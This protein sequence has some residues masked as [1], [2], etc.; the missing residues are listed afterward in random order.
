MS[1]TIHDGGPAFPVPPSRYFNSQQER[2]FE[3]PARPCMSLRDWFAGQ[4]LAGMIA[5][6][7]RI[8][9]KTE[10]TPNDYVSL[11]YQFAES[12]LRAREAK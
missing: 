10:V 5:S 2:Y 6:G 7:S 8:N 11:A 12:M 3:T 9:S 1:D 4:A